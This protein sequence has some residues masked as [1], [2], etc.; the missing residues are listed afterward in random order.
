M[1][2]L[3]MQKFDT[4]IPL[5]LYIHLP[6]CVQKC[7]YCDFN[8]HK[9]PDSLPEE[10]Y[11]NALI[12]DLEENLPAIWGRRLISIFFGGGT[13]S[14]F[15]AQGIERILT[16]VN[17]RLRFGPEIEITL[18][19]NPGTI[20]ESRFKDYRLAGINRLSLGLQSLQDEKLKTLGRIH[21]REYALR[22]IEIA[23]QAGFEN[24]NLDL[25]H[26][27]PNQS[28]DEALSDLRTALAYQ[29]THLSWYQL[30]IEPNTLFHHNPPELPAE[31]VLWEIQT[32]GKLLLAEHGY[33]QY[34]VSAYS[35]PQKECAHNMNYWEFGDYLGIG[36]GAH[37]KLTDLDKQQ[38]T[39]Y[40]QVKNPRDYLNP[41]KKFRG[42]ERILSAS[43]TSFEFMMNALR[44]THGVTTQLFTKR[45]GLSLEVIEPTLR[46][47]R[48]KG[49]LSEDN[50]LLQPTE[51]G[52]RFLNDLVEMFLIT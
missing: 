22:A 24:F 41:N 17:T 46:L 33:Q 20:D 30:T 18:E 31:E 6:W 12:Q 29:P 48:Q 27:L 23:K 25:M 8:S 52:Q 19:A 34:E 9:A 32:Q 38:I 42:E 49:L 2:N 43:E 37:S 3:A 13:P 15:S 40:S 35:K 39:R 45:T 10:L 11:I 16:E 5:S 4:T 21:N 28:V 36:A 14:L 51:L 1:Y 47:A 44:L 7:P 50:L 26:G